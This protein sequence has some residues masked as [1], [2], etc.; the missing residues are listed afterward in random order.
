MKNSLLVLLFVFSNYLNPISVYVTIGLNLIIL[1][2][3]Y[4]NRRLN[5]DSFK[6]LGSSLILV[7]WTI[8]VMFLNVQVDG[9]VFGKYLRV[10]IST[11]LIINICNSLSIRAKEINDAISLVFIGH[12]I[13]IGLQILFPSLDLPMAKFFQFDREAEVITA[14]SIRKLGLSSSYDTAALISVAGMIFFFMKYK[15][16]NKR[17]FIVFAFLFLISTVSISRTGM[18]IGIL[19]FFIL[20][21][22]YYFTAKKRD[23]LVTL[24]FLFGGVIV[25]LKFILPIIASTTDGFLSNTS[26][27]T[28]NN[29]NRDYTEGSVTGLTE[30]SHLNAIRN[31]DMLE[32]FFGYGIDP[33]RVQNLQTDIGYIKLVYHVGIIG[34]II[35]ML[36]YWF[37]FKK[38]WRINKNTI[39]KNTKTT[40]SFLIWYIILIVIFNYK[41]LELYSRGTHDLVLILF[42]VLLHSFAFERKLRQFSP[43]S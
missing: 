17:I 41:S 22:N 5:T 28:F 7:I 36:L 33:N 40:A 4:K 16:S 18:V 32:L 23:I 31:V 39:D 20:Y 25:L 6:V 29:S 10:F 38:I 43:S 19:L 9:Y 21:L 27:K 2:S 34:L 37:F 1:A 8:L 26:Y 42:F 24:T 13:A 11:F 35:I 30:G 15:F 12:L 3:F 14:Y